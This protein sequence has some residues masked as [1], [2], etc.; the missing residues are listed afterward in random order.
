MSSSSAGS[1]F[2]VGEGWPDPIPG[3]TVV[4]LESSIVLGSPTL[5]EADWA[6]LARGPQVSVMLVND[7]AG[8]HET[9]TRRPDGRLTNYR[10][11]EIR[12]EP[13]PVPADKLDWS[14]YTSWVHEVFGFEGRLVLWDSSRTW[15]ILEDDGLE[16]T[17]VCAPAGMFPHETYP[18]DWLGEPGNTTLHAIAR[19]YGISVDQPG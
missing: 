4:M 12:D 2:G 5:S 11:T 18:A 14:S 13:V 8:F 16:L 10:R 17:I 6:R 7:H 1:P 15:W 19:R 3:N 9:W